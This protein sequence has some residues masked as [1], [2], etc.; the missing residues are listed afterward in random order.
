MK[1]QHFITKSKA[2]ILLVAGLGAAAQAQTLYS[3]T[4][5]F[6]QFN[7]GAGV[8]SSLYYSI[9]STVNG[10]GNSSNAGGTGG[11]GS[12]QLAS[13]VGYGTIPGGGFTGPTAA[14]F[15]TLSLGSTRPYSPESG[16]GPGNMLPASGTISYDVYTGNLVGYNYVQFGF[17][18]NYDGNYGQFFSS[19]TSTFTGA[20]GNTWLHVVIP[21]TTSATAL[22]YFGWSLMEN[23][24]GTGVGGETIYIDN[25]QITPVPEPGTLALAAA[26]GV[27]LLLWR[28]RFARLV[29]RAFQRAG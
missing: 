11:I 5:D 4:N 6:A 29:F 23:S 19:S 9:A 8:V 2:V 20:D 28:R 12:L 18:L 10:V 16:Y 3:T 24:G 26:G 22:N 13:T 21:Y 25:I 27:A 14:A 17:N 15:Q 7:S 1:M